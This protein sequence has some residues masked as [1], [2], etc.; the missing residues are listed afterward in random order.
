MSTYYISSL[1]FISLL[2]PIKLR[3]IAAGDEVGYEEKSLFLI[4]LTRDLDETNKQKTNVDY[5]LTFKFYDIFCRYACETLMKK[6]D[7]YVSFLHGHDLVHITRNICDH[8][9]LAFP[10]LFNCC[11]SVFPISFY[12]R[13]GT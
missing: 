3:Q 1:F 10:F 2:I 5:I 9:S 4:N 12:D 8:L 6:R 11:K 13:A 7:K